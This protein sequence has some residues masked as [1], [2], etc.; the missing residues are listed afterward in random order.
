MTFDTPSGNLE[1]RLREALKGRY[2]I[3]RELAG[4]GMSRVFVARETALDRQVVLK[5]LPPELAAEVNRDRFRQEVQFAAKLQHPHIVPLLS[6]GEEYGLLY[7]T[8]PYIDGSSLKA[9]I[10]TKRRFTEEEAV[11]ILIDV[12]DALSYAHAANIVHRDIK[13]ANILRTGSHAVVTDFGVAKAITAAMRNRVGAMGITT[14]GV[15]IGTPAYMAPEQIAAD[16]A[17]DHRVDIYAMGLLAYELLS[18]RAPFTGSSPQAMLAAQIT[19][20]AEPLGKIRTDLSPMLLALIERCLE[21]EASRRPGSAASVLEILRT[22]S[23]TSGASRVRPVSAGPRWPLIAAGVAVLAMAGVAWNSMARGKDAELLANA[24]LDSARRSD[25]ILQATMRASINDSAGRAQAQREEQRRLQRIA[26]S[27]A[28]VQRKAFD[29]AMKQLQ[30]SGPPVQTPPP[31]SNLPIPGVS[32][33]AAE[34]AALT[35]PEAFQ[36]RALNMGPP[37]RVFVEVGSNM[38]R[39]ADVMLRGG[40]VRDSIIRRLG[41]SGRYRPIPTDSTQHALAKT[42]NFDTLSILTNAEVFVTL[43]TQPA[44]ADSVLWIAEVRD[45]TANTQLA[46]RSLSMMGGPIA[47]GLDFN[48]TRFVDSVVRQLAEVDRAPRRPA[49]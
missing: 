48:L 25:S 32:A 4:G 39:A 7:Y 29:S 42:R 14:S 1:E 3:E 15:A 20:R 31:V 27:F 36:A 33:A 11:E 28:T 5:V 26:D 19:G 2:E 35:S 41:A 30:K 9:D 12:A 6:A 43:R 34:R 37:R 47:D 13:P 8:M 22:I 45:L 21:K 17:A 49:R 10:A 24:A 46:V 44:R 16:P 38:I 23:L 18:G 40:V